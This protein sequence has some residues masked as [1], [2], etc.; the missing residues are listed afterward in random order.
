MEL[1]TR[2]TWLRICLAFSAEKGDRP[3]KNYIWWWGFSSETVRNVES[4]FVSITLSSFLTSDDTYNLTHYSF[5]YVYLFPSWHFLPN[6]V[7]SII[8]FDVFIE[9]EPQTLISATVGC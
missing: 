5:G 6:N 1:T 8:R 9:T 2:P 7:V 4:T 3:A